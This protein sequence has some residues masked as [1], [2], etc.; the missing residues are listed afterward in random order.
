[1]FSSSKQNSH[2]QIELVGTICDIVE[3]RRSQVP[4]FRRK[5]QARTRAK[6][7]VHHRA[8]ILNKQ[9]TKQVSLAWLRGAHL[10]GRRIIQSESSVEFESV[11]GPEF[12][13][14]PPADRIQPINWSG[15]IRGVAV[16]KHALADV[17][18]NSANRLPAK[19]FSGEKHAR[20]ERNFPVCHARPAV[21]V[22]VVIARTSRRRGRGLRA[23]CPKLPAVVTSGSEA[24]R[25]TKKG[26]RPRSPNRVSWLTRQLPSTGLAKVRARG[27]LSSEIVENS[28]L[29][30]DVLIRRKFK[31]MLYP[32]LRSPCPQIPG[33]VQRR[34]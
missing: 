23:R 16:I 5:Q 12:Q 24:Q 19:E 31:S 29:D 4:V 20:A 34:D 6:D 9:R 1:M 10:R 18:A 2:N 14:R 7:S 22:V 15:R 27:E 21:D 28:A 33:V 11:G 13:L 8:A 25:L 26:V 17:A 30:R 3:L 32:N